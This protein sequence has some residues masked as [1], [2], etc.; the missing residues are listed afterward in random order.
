MLVALLAGFLAAAGCSDPAA[1]DKSDDPTLKAS[2]QKSMEI[3]KSKTQ[4][5][6]G[7]PAAAKA[8]AIESVAAIRTPADERPDG[9]RGRR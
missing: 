1:T 2:M 8:A 4:A 5:I 6:K 9:P 7:N 3:Y